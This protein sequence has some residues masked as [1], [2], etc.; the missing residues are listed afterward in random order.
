[1]PI[2]KYANSQQL[3]SRICIARM[4][5][6]DSYYK[7]GIIVKVYYLINII[8]ILTFVLTCVETIFDLLLI[9]DI[10]VICET[11]QLIQES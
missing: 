5:F 1:M 7:R 10:I 2:Y 3:Y 6:V 8:S 11:G 4:K 9:G